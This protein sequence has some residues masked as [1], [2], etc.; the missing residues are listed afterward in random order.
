MTY[1]TVSVVLVVLLCLLNLTLTIGVIRRLRERAGDLA[2]SGLSV[3]ALVV[4]PG[5]SVGSFSAV[6]TEG[7]RLSQDSLAEGSMVLFMSPGCP[8]CEDLLPLVAERAGEYGRDRVLAVVT[9]DEEK[10]ALLGEYLK[11]LSPVA[12]V[13]VTEFGDE[14]TEA[15][16]LKGLPAY[17]EMGAAGRVASSGRTLPHRTEPARAGA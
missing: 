8:A 16:A 10:D 5:G 14:L 12:R 1:L 9:R 17:V 11:R 4:G 3:P 15:F 13:V 6:D 7:E 2:G